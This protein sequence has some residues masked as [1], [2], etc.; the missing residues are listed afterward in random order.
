MAEEKFYHALKVINEKCI[1]C[2]HCMTGCPTS[3]IRIKNGKATI[4]ADACIDCGECMKA[5]PYDAIILE[6]DDF[7]D[8]YN[9]KYRVALIPAV[10]IGQFRS[11][12]EEERIYTEIYKLGFTHVFEVES[13]VDIL[14]DAMTKYIDLDIGEKP[15]I[16]SFCPAIVR[17]IQIRFPSL[18]D[19]II[20]YRTPVDIAANYY[21]K[22]LLDERIKE[23]DI[24]IFYV[25]PCASKIAAVKSP[26]G[27]EQS[28]VDGVINMDLLFNKVYGAIKQAPQYETRLKLD[29]YLTEK[30]VKWS[31]TGGESVNFKGRCLAIDEIHNVIAF[32]EKVENEEIKHVNFLELRA[33]DESCCGGVLL[34]ENRF[35]IGERLKDRAEKYKECKKIDNRNI[36]G[37]YRNFLNKNIKIESP[38]QER[39]MHKLDDDM[40]MAMTKMQRLNQLMKYLPQIDCG[41]CGAP[42]CKDLARDI[43]QEN[44]KITQ[45]VFLQKYLGKKNNISH[46]DL[47]KNVENIWGEKR[48]DMDK[49]NKYESI[50]D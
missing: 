12:I 8:I 39:S 11:K 2:T 45:C 1:G 15:Y 35:L 25:T 41:A 5:C 13:T 26:I 33:C 3:A 38:I 20:P 43:V 29:Q 42:R 9:F 49:K 24:G 30:Q 48:F 17:L 27:E 7:N 44:A 4:S 34:S 28:G 31:L 23:K 16:S 46:Q 21:R 36:I 50:D 19:N 37:K 32:L 18:I 10:F 40:Q 6:Q 14:H 22:K 47:L